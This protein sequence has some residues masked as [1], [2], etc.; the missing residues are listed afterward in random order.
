M[1]LS[2]HAGA[3]LASKELGQLARILQAARFATGKTCPSR[4]SRAAASYKRL[5]ISAWSDQDRLYAARECA[6]IPRRPF[7]AR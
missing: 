7:L 1:P 5:L 3:Y 2:P 4:E 6:Y